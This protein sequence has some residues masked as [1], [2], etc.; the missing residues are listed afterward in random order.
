MLT[1]FNNANK[2]LYVMFRMNEFGNDTLR[3]GITPRDEHGDQIKEESVSFYVFRNMN[4]KL[5]REGN[6][7]YRDLTNFLNG[8]KHICSTYEKGNP[9][10]EKLQ[11]SDTYTNVKTDHIISFAFGI[12]EKEG[13]PY[14]VLFIRDK[15]KDKE[16]K[17]TYT[18]RDDDELTRFVKFLKMFLS[19]SINFI[20]HL[21]VSELKEIIKDS[22]GDQLRVIVRDEIRQLR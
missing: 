8:I 12:T 19:K 3:I 10:G 4:Y 13:V 14:R 21:V 7:N 17:Q 2:T 22:V 18:F 6:I 16:L 9:D 20:C 1:Y 5:S 11:F 15:F